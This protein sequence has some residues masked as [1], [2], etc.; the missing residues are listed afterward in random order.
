MRRFIEGLGRSFI[1]LL[2]IVLLER[3]HE[4]VQG[5]VRSRRRS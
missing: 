4:W 2:V 1:L 3:G 5:Q